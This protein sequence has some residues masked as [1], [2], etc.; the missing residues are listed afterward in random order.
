MRRTTPSISPRVQQPQKNR[1]LYIKPY[2]ALNML[3]SKSVPV[4]ETPETS[5]SDFSLS[6]TVDRTALSPCFIASPTSDF[7]PSHSHKFPFRYTEH[8]KFPTFKD[9]IVGN[10]ASSL[11][12]PKTAHPQL[13][14]LAQALWRIFWKCEAFL[15]EIRASH[16]GFSGLVVHDARFGFDDAAFR[17]AGRQETVHQLRNTEEEVPEEVEAEKDGIVYVKCVSLPQLFCNEKL[18]MITRLQGD[19]SVG[20]LGKHPTKHPY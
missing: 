18:T 7:D 6:L 13:I 1:S 16:S 2:Q 19:G 17:S 15:L 9:P 4:S 20:T 3:K 11:Q 8:T 12:L 10:I 5:E 14:G